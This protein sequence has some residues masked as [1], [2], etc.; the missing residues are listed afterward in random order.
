MAS[1]SLTPVMKNGA[2]RNWAELPY[3]LTLSIL[4]RLDIVDILVNAQKVCVS[5]RRVCKDPAMWRKID[6]SNLEGFGYTLERMCR[7]VV[8]RSHGGLLEVDISNFATHSLLE[9]IADRLNSPL[10][11]TSYYLQSCRSSSLRSLRNCHLSMDNRLAE[12]IAKLPLLEELDITFGTSLSGK[13][14]KVVGQSCPNLKTLKLNR[15]L[16][17]CPRDLRDD[18]ALA[19]AETMPGL[20]FLQLLGSSLSDFGLNAILDCCPDLEHLNLRWCHNIKL[21]GDL[22]KRCSE[23]IKVLRR[24]RDSADDFPYAY[25]YS[26]GDSYDDYD[27]EDFDYDF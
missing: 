13:S 6:M 1:S 2:C 5:W 4:R 8:D 3:E 26:S 10:G 11:I 21:A 19:I 14:L 27:P 24:P 22:E 25:A 12:A 17:M 16:S 7:H 20:R 9:Y 23:R 18:D 15:D